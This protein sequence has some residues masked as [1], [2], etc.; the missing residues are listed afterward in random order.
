MSKE[1]S[2]ESRVDSSPKSLRE[3][4]YSLKELLQKMENERTQEFP[5]DGDIE[6]EF[7]ESLLADHVT[8]AEIRIVT[9]GVI[10]EK[11][12]I[13]IPSSQHDI[14]VEAESISR[15]G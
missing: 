3:V 15:V 7:W 4:R 8:N 11:R 9:D 1:E 2:S 5:F 10:L 13:N 12:L 14:L 6:V